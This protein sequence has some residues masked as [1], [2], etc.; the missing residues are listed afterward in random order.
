[1]RGTADKAA[2]ASGDWSALIREDEGNEGDSPL[3]KMA[4][5]VREVA[6]TLL[7]VLAAPHVAGVFVEGRAMRRNLVAPMLFG[8]RRR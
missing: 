2:V 7:L 5:E 6:S 4:E 3:R 1:M 8:E